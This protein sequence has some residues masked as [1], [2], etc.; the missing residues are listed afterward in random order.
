MGHLRH[1][2]TCDR[3]VPRDSLQR[4][5]ARE[6]SAHGSRGGN[7]PPRSLGKPGAGRRG[8]GDLI[9]SIS[10]ACEMQSAETVLS[11]LQERGK[12]RLPLTRLYRQLF[13]PQLFLLAYGRLYS[14]GGAM[15]PGA[16]GETV[17]GMSLEKIEQSL[18]RCAMSA[19]GGHQSSGSTFRRKTGSCV[20]SACQRGP[21]NWSRK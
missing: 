16:T 7:V 6:R 20:R 8:T 5:T 19:F 14:N 17:D 3:D 9:L 11:I 12:R 2:R 21:T 13:N 10:E 18:T 1:A 4:A 15:T